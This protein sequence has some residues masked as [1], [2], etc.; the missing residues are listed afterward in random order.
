MKTSKGMIIL[1]LDFE[2]ALVTVTN[3]VGLAEGT[4]KNSAMK[5]GVHYYDGLKFHRV[6]KDFMIQGGDP[7]GTG[8]GGPG[9][10]FNDE[11][12]RELRHNGPGIISMANAGPDT[13][14]SQFF[15]THRAT[16]HL[17]DKHSVFGRVVKG[18]EVVNTIEQGDLIKEIT[19]LRI[20]EKAKAFKPNNEAFHKLLKDQQKK[21]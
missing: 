15:I 10:R 16:P 6:I 19:I 7:T 17:D 14:G 4:I 1:K 13:N 5:P 2:R 12:N 8:S 11:F 21:R 3:F 18:M 9:Y 20:G